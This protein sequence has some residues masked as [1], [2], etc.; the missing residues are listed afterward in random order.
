VPRKRV[1]AKDVVRNLLMQ[2]LEGR[3]SRVAIEDPWELVRRGYLDTPMSYGARLAY[4]AEP[5]TLAR[6]YRVLDRTTDELRKSETLRANGGIRIAV[7]SSWFKVPHKRLVAEGPHDGGRPQ[8]RFKSRNCKLQA[9][10]DIDTRTC[11]AMF[12]QDEDE[13]DHAALAVLLGLVSRRFPIAEV[14]AD[15]GYESEENYLRVEAHGAV[16]WLDF[17]DAAK[18]PAPGTARRRGWDRYRE[19]DATLGKTKPRVAVEGWFSVVKRNSARFL[20]AKHRL[21]AET[22]L[23]SMV[24]VANMRRALI[25]H[26]TTGMAIPYADERA[27]EVIGADGNAFVKAAALD[28]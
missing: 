21:Q 8:W 9:A 24:V 18:E 23:V 19:R 3:S 10:V 13:S 25:L 14:H 26:A 15:N 5:N 11:V 28:E 6:L 27:M 7:D 4:M 12:V 17:G 16:P 20:R 2:S 22:E 1:P